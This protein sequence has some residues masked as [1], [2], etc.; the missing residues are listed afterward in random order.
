MY[1][2]LLD[3]YQKIG[4]SLPKKWYVSWGEKL[5][6]KLNIETLS[7]TAL[8]ALQR[9]RQLAVLGL[10]PPNTDDESADRIDGVFLPSIFSAFACIG[11]STLPMPN[12]IAQVGACNIEQ[13]GDFWRKFYSE[14][15]RSLEIEKAFG[16]GLS[17]RP[18]PIAL[19]L[20]QR[21]SQTF[22]R[23][24]TEQVENVPQ[25]NAELQLSKETLEQ[26]KALKGSGFEEIVAAFEQQMSVRQQE[27]QGKLN[28]WLED[29]ESDESDVEAQ[30][31]EQ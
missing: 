12:V 5:G 30:V 15:A 2:T 14:L 6:M 22:K 16:A 24:L 4:P 23:Q 19:F 13:L 21:Y 29:Q 1:R 27:L 10:S 7:A 25:L 8:S 31:A 18:L 9:G 28:P 26:L 3:A 11:G 20:R 17:K